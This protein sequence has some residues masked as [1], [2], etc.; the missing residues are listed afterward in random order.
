M[1]TLASKLAPLRK[2]RMR[3]SVG[4]RDASMVSADVQWEDFLSGVR[5]RLSL[6]PASRVR[7][8][9][10]LNVEVTRIEDLCHGDELIVV[11]LSSREWDVQLM[12][13]PAPHPQVRSALCFVCVCDS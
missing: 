12:Q 5:S 1:V 8:Y 7:V 9:D 10:T 13:H 11:P 3:V 6:G 4:L 2:F